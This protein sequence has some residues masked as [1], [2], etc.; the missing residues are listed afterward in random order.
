MQFSVNNLWYLLIFGVQMH[1]AV[2]G[3]DVCLN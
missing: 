3:N 2:L 1:C